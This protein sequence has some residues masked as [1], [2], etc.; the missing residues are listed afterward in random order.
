MASK[1]P[2]WDYTRPDLPNIFRSEDPPDTNSGKPDTADAQPSG[3]GVRKSNALT[4]ED[5]IPAIPPT[6]QAGQPRN[7][8][9][10]QPT[11]ATQATNSRPRGPKTWAVLG[12][13]IAV[14]LATAGI[15]VGI[16]GV[17]HKS[18][19]GTGFAPANIDPD[20]IISYAE[21]WKGIN[22][23][24]LMDDTGAAQVTLVGFTAGGQEIEIHHF[25]TFVHAYRVSG[26]AIYVVECDDHFTSSQIF[27]I[28]AG[29]L[30]P[31]QEPSLLASL[32]TCPGQFAV[33]KNKA[34]YTPRD[35]PEGTP[36]SLIE[37]DLAPH[38]ESRTIDIRSTL[39]KNSRE[40]NPDILGLLST[41]DHLIYYCSYDVD[42]SESIYN[43]ESGVSFVYC[44]YCFTEVV[45][46]HEII[47]SHNTSAYEEKGLDYL[48]FD[49]VSQASQPM[50]GHRYERIS[51]SGYGWAAYTAVGTIAVL[52]NGY[53]F[54]VETEFYDDSTSSVDLYFL[55]TQFEVHLLT[56]IDFAQLYNLTILPTSSSKILLSVTLWDSNGNPQAEMIQTYSLDGELLDSSTKPMTSP[57]HLAYVDVQYPR[58]SA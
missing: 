3:P 14:A 39:C 55:D 17:T 51:S 2:E 16:W 24:Y 9:Q 28:P 19:T 49:T 21:R 23:N 41:D 30:S 8:P 7:Q 57:E 37:L 48:T 11:P 22:P 1:P 15:I 10:P 31:G 4:F 12:V 38:G 27:S 26:A 45:L 6:P 36:T 44:Q 29:G 58:F 52:P 25:A 50:A 42:G 53:V 33:L 34:Y 20:T 56:T 18:T 46:S 40:P 54:G 35:L 43:P 47:Y 32:N 13:G 5:P